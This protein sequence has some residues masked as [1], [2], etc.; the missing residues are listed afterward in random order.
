[1]PEHD[2]L[3]RLADA[4][5]IQHLLQSI[6]SRDDFSVKHH[7]QIPGFDSRAQCRAI[8]LDA[9]HPHAR[10]ILDAVM[11]RNAPSQRR[12]RPGNPKP[13]APHA[14]VG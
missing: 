5:G 8:A 10:S 2:D 1:M 3:A 4:L 13:P 14:A 12:I 11:S 9:S 6:Y 7:D